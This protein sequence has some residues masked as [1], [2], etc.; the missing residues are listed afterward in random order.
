M[1]SCARL[2]PRLR[3]RGPP[4][5][6]DAASTPDNNDHMNTTNGNN[7]TEDMIII[8]NIYNDGNNDDIM[9]TYTNTKD[10]LPLPPN[11]PPPL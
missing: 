9:E 1:L 4:R 8:P 10:N 5:H 3:L 7:E 6:A 11:T 2:L